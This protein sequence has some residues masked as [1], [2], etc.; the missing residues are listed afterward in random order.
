MES[1]TTHI[2]LSMPVALGD[3]SRSTEAR[4]S[5]RRMANGKTEHYRH[6]LNY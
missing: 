5:E 2:M 4:E 3:G 1:D 6:L